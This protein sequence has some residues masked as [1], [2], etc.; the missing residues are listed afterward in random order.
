MDGTGE[1]YR[2]RFS[3]ATPC[4]FTTATADGS[5]EAYAAAVRTGGGL[6]SYGQPTP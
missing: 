6:G 1:T 5:P 2:T 4:L 3:K